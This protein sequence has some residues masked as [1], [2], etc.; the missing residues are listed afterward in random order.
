MVPPNTHIQLGLQCGE[1]R[2]GRLQQDIPIAVYPLFGMVLDRVRQWLHVEAYAVL[3]FHQ[4][5]V[6][7]IV[8]HFVIVLKPVIKVDNCRVLGKPLLYGGSLQQQGDKP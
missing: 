4:W 7:D 5:H 6:L 1:S 3:V 8:H 2:L